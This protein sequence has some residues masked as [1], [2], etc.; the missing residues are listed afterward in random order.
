MAGEHRS[1]ALTKL[2]GETEP[3]SKACFV[4][5]SCIITGDADD[6]ITLEASLAESVVRRPMDEI[7]QDKTFAALIRQGQ[8][9]GDAASLSDW[10][11]NTWQSPI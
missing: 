6:A 7:D 10:A 4:S 5:V 1:H 3:Q 8:S 11:N 2:N 9:V